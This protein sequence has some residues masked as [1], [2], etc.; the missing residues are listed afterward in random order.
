MKINNVVFLIA[1]NVSYCYYEK[2][3]SIKLEYGEYIITYVG[4]QRT[5][6]T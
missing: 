6:G 2:D 5:R 1:S 4:I 3:T